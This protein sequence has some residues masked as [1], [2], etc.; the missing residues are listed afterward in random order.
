MIDSLRM[1]GDQAAILAATIDAAA[2]M[3]G[4][5][6]VVLLNGRDPGGGVEWMAIAAPFLLAAWLVT[7]TVFALKHC[8]IG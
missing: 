8:L 3:F 2:I 6:Q 7:G 1:I 5:E 4:P